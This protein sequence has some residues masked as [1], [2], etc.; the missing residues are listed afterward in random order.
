V[1]AEAEAEAEAVEDE[2]GRGGSK[3]EIKPCLGTEAI[4]DDVSSLTARS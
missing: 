4:D 3:A 1:E 2:V